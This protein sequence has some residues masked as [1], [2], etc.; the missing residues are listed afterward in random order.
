[1]R[2]GY[3]ITPLV[4]ASDESHLAGVKQT[5]EALANGELEEFRLGLI[6]GRLPAAE[7]NHVMQQFADGA[8]QVLVATS[9]V[10]VGVNVPNATIMTIE[11]GQQFGLAQLHQLRGRIR[12]GKYKGFLCVFADPSTEESVERLEA[13]VELDDGFRLAEVDFELRGPG[14][15]FSTRQHG[16][17]PFRIARLP[18]D[19]PI[20]DEARQDAHQML[21]Q[22]PG[23]QNPE[24]ATLRHRVLI[25]Y[26]DVLDLGDVG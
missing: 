13:L 20:L 4:D 12:R 11:D 8:I 19:F 21:K 15:L 2:Q 9:V 3:V 23:L 16:L 7:K 6:H 24:L 17:P 26:G 25:R 18:A 10:E 14:D 22:D 1:G 5:Y